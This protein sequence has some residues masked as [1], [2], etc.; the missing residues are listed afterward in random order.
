[1]TDIIALIV[2]TGVAFFLRLSH[3]VAKPFWFDECFS[4][5]LARLNWNNFIHVLWWREANMT[6]YY[7]V[8]RLWLHVGQS[9]F[10]IRS[11]S[12]LIATA[13]VPA[14]YWVSKLLFSRPVALIAAALFTFN[15]YNIRYAQETR[16]YA[17]FALLGTLSSGF[18]VAWLR[19]PS[20]SHYAGY[21]IASILGIYS[22]L[23]FLLL[24]LA[25]W[26]A[27]RTF[28]WPQPDQ[29]T[30]ANLAQLRRAWKAFA[31]AS[32]P[33]IIFV[34]KTGAGPIRW[35][36][37]PGIRDLLVFWKQFCGADG[38]LLPAVFAA[39]CILLGIELFRRHSGRDPRAQAW[40]LQFLFVWLLF[41]IVLTI[42]LSF[43]RPVFLPR[44]MIFAHPALLILTAVAILQMHRAWLIA[45]GLAA[46]LFLSWQGVCFAYHNDFDE[47]RDG[48][49]AA[50]NFVLDHSR[51]GDAIIFDIAEA[52]VPYEF[53]RSERAGQNTASS[54]FTAL[55]GPEILFPNDGPGLNYRDFR[56]RL[57]PSFL[58][59][60]APN[61]ERV[62]VFLIY[63]ENSDPTTTAL[64]RTLPQ[65]FPQV[66][67]WHFPRVEIQLYHR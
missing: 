37:R 24:I 4:V 1:L 46:I 19:S 13:T 59:A 50:T 53:F 57:T 6:L 16:S 18:L 8:L 55:L 52:R 41:P 11:L 65:W 51:T 54:S 64:K 48:S 25:H 49:G 23:Y 34:I 2:L 32:V 28:G 29:A 7:L 66:E 62:W 12:V 63:N 20:R 35:I 43:A 58:S 30:E 5:E 36:H 22:H 38:W 17:L 27:L 44:Y 40:P 45:P 47:Q 26:L 15:A 3:L 39:A 31:I 42:V 14:I 60:A 9:E 10:F 33:L 56:A 67:S 21:L 61:H